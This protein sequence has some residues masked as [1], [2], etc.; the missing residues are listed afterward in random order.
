MV[1]LLH[2]GSGEKRLED[3][4]A[5]ALTGLGIANLLGLGGTTAPI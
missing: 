3:G 4:R 2:K 5:V 1:E